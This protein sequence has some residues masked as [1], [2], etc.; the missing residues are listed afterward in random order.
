ME[1]TRPVESQFTFFQLQQAVVADQPLG[2]G[3]KAARSFDMAAA[4]S[5]AVND[6][7]V[8]REMKV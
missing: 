7:R 5:A 6:E 8:K 2:A 4:S 1:V 3:L